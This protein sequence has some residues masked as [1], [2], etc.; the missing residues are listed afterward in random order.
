[1]YQILDYWTNYVYQSKVWTI[2]MWFFGVFHIQFSA[3]DFLLKATVT[4]VAH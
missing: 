3:Y 2:L 4:A 1:L